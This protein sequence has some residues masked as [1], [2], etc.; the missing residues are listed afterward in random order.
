MSSEQEHGGMARRGVTRPMHG[1]GGHEM[2]KEDRC[3]QL[4]QHHARTQWVYWS[5]ILA[6]VWTLF[7]PVTLGYGA[8]IAEPSGGRSIWLSDAARITA[9]QVSDVASGL[10]LIF[11]GWRSLQPDRPYS[12]WAAC[13]VGVWLTF[14]PLV[15]WAPSAAAYL[16]AT[17]VGAAVIALTILVP[18]MPNMPMYMKMGPNQPP[19]W[20]Y[21]PSS[22][23]QRAILIALAFV[24]WLVSRYLAAYQLGYIETVWDPFFG[25]GTR[26][27]L[28]SKMSHSLPVSDAGLGALAFTFEFLMGWMGSQAR[29]R[30][31]PW[32]V[33]FFGILVIPLGLVHIFLVISQPVV[34]GSWCTFC[35]LAAALMLPMI[36]LSADEVVAMLQHLRGA[37]RRGESRWRVFWLG[38]APEGSQPDERTPEVPELPRKPGLLARASVWGMTLPWTLVLSVAIGIFLMAV[39]GTF[40][41]GKPAASVFHLGGALVV[42]TAVIAMA[43]VV[44]PLR[45]LDALLGLVIAIGPLILDGAGGTA[46]LIG[47]VAG[48]ALVVLAVPRGQVRDRYASWDKVIV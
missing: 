23:P 43:E 42:T 10:L 41:V 45:F 30:T 26:Q 36:G 19:G 6:G 27:V 12:L 17:V 11:F 22:W 7:A 48:L 44:R 47:I 14:A 28:D 32:M 3:D 39:P 34:V 18:G 29:W 2:T 5:I 37:K 40:D 9:M 25:D 46:R 21:N 33:G 8:E 1:G 38:G 13:F 35:L 4:R 31:M 15:F 20:T 16:N 24:G